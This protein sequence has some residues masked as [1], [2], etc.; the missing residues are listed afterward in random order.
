MLF[1]RSCVFSRR[2]MGFFPLVTY[3][4]QSQIHLKLSNPATDTAS[5]SIAKWDGAKGIWPLAAIAE[6]PLRLKCGR[7]WECV[8]IMTDGIVTKR[9]SGLAKQ[10]LRDKILKPQSDVFVLLLWFLQHIFFKENVLLIVF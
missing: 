4:K 9:E 1:M 10:Q 5:H 2:F 3:P 8:F 7:L 6:P